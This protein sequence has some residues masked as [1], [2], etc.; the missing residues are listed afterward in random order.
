MKSFILKSLFAVLILACGTALAADVVILSDGSRSSADLSGEWGMLPIDG[1][2]F[3]FPPPEAGWKKQVIPSAEIPGLQSQGGPYCPNVADVLTKDR[4]DFLRKTGVASWFKRE[5]T[6]PKSALAK[7]R[8][9]LCFEGIA[10]KSEV[11]V[12]G[13]K[14]G[15]SVFGQLPSSYDITDA[16]REGKPNELVVGLTDREGLV[17]LANQTFIAP[18]SGVRVGIWGK[19]ELQFVPL[20]RI[21][22]VF[23]KTSVKNKKID[24]DVSLLNAGSKPATVSVGALISDVKQNPT[25]E[26]PP[27]PVT[28]APGES[29]TIA[30]SKD[31]IAPHLWS[32]NDPALYFAKVSINRAGSTVDSSTIRFGF[33]EFEIRGRDFFLNGVRTVLL[34]NSHLC[35]LTASRP[36]M[37]SR[38][39]AEAGNPTNCIRLHLGF[40]PSALLDLCDELGVMSVPE[41]AWN[42]AVDSKTPA[43]KADLWLPNVESYTR[44]FI[45]LHRN[46]PSVVIWSLTNESIWGSTSPEHMRVADGLLAAAKEVDSTRPFGGDGEVS[47]GGR[48][49]VI[50]VHYPES[51]IGN[52]LRVKYPNSGAVLPNDAHWLQKDAE[53]ESWR[54]KFK[55]DRPLILGEYWYPAGEAD[56]FS[57]FMGESVYDWEKWRSQRM[58]GCGVG[59]TADNEFVRSQQ[60]LTDAYRQDGVAG[61]NPWTADGNKAMPRLALRPVDFFP[62]FKSGTTGVRKFVIFNDSGL[63]YGNMNLQCRLTVNGESVWE[64]NIPAWVGPGET[65][66]FEIPV[67]CPAVTRQVQAELSLR[68]RFEQS[69]GWHQLDRSVETVFIMPSESLAELDAKKVFLL[70]N[71]ARTAKAL[72]GLGLSLNP[73]PKVTAGDL[74]GKN[75]LIVGEE[76]DPAAGKDVIVDFV[77]AGG[78]AIVLR[79]DAW[80]PLVG[81]LPESDKEHVSTRSWKRTYDH[82]ITAGMDDRQFSYWRPDHLVSIKTFRKPAAG[83]YQSL[84]DCGGLYGLRWS[85]LLEV[86]VG[87]GAFLL[88]SLDLVKKV[89]EEPAAAH[90]LA[91]MVRY[92]SSRQAPVRPPLRLLDQDNKALRAVLIA[93]GVVFEEGLGEKG[94]IL[95]DA[96]F[97]PT[98]DDLAKIKSRLAPGGHVW[99]HGFG[100]ETIKN[101]ASL[102]PF[103]P[104]LQSWDPTVQAAVRR[105]EDPLMNNL[106][107]FDFFWTRVDLG[108]RADYFAEA[109][110][111]AKLGGLELKLPNLEAGVCL[112][113]PALLVKVPVGK[114]TLLFDNILWQDALG[115][116]TDK[117]TRIVSALAANQGAEV[118]TA[119]EEILYDYFPVDISKQANMGYYDRVANDGKGGWT[120]QGENDMRFFLINHVGKMGGLESG[121]DIEGQNF[122]SEVSMAGRRFWLLD[123]RKTSDHAV[124]S[125]RGEEHGALLPS[126]AE[127]IAVGK[128]AE[129][130]WFLQ[131]AGWTPPNF[132]Q[133]VARY[134]IH[135]AD[136]SQE[137]F[138]IRYGREISEWWNPWPIPGAKIAWS[139]RNLVQSS[140]GI[141]ATQWINPHPGKAIATID[142]IGNLSPT[143]VILLAITGGTVKDSTAKGQVLSSWKTENFN[144]K[145]VPNQVPQASPLLAGALPPTLV[146]TAGK[147]RLHFQGGQSL[148]GNLKDLPAMGGLGN[149]KPFAVKITFTPESLPTYPFAGLFQAASYGKS[150]FRVMLD[151]RMK[152][153]VEIFTGEETGGQQ[154]VC[155]SVPIELGRPCTVE[156]RFDGT[157]VTLLLNGQVDKME[158]SPL[159]APFSDG[160]LIGMASGKNYDFT[161]II[162]EVSIYG[163]KEFGM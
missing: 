17:D 133:E 78:T 46:R 160:F 51:T 95:L 104:V 118:R 108:A 44:Q 13:K 66:V 7:H 141:Y 139:G 19:V 101:V 1:L 86:P 82:P 106:S 60:V 37:F 54:A 144:G 84:L 110:P 23:V 150:G 92:A 68:L 79:Q 22:D 134:I 88:S 55:W 163:L 152:I 136:G 30:L 48:L 85:P 52:S 145:S 154:G 59:S 70:A 36:T 6:L 14:V 16:L 8:V 69:G 90:L 155:S 2:Q 49:S 18:A 61:V 149:G 153:V 89:G 94:P 129:S 146:E 25:A 40:V 45:K 121:P 159:P 99:L 83:L 57:S 39:R 81:E 63:G 116:E 27:V 41:S 62:N 76:T 58:D 142:V 72:A 87:R 143:Q 138:P 33:R 12:N 53:N 124:I 117:T 109:H 122:P 64:K 97:I 128:K 112:I 130:L 161:G 107:T 131:A 93:A 50:N 126:K 43:E 132:E 10:F 115:A 127:G 102:F 140:I 20:V 119:T 31:W 38:V 67:E 35:D 100:K 123:P 157:Y 4:K 156:V 29:K 21:D 15:S 114:G 32:P 135:Y 151:P 34:R 24:L 111:T 9:L 158:K 98:A 75:V 147:R 96:T 103:E 113:A 42:F 137:T 3:Q 11:W 80:V 91:N 105:S 73:S 125:L 56:G 74:Q 162:D 71:D 26:I 65:K 120:D 47:W 148:A 5:F 28:L 77:K